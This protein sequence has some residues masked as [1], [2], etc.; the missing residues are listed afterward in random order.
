MANG[1]HLMASQSCRN[2]LKVRFQTLID[3]CFRQ[4]ANGSTFSMREA[5]SPAT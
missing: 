5:R 2:A 1:R 4:A 3:R